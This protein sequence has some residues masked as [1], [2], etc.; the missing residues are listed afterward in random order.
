MR[1][2]NFCVKNSGGAVA[3]DDENEYYNMLL[4]KTPVMLLIDVAIN[5]SHHVMIAHKTARE[6]WVIQ[7]FAE[8]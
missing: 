5:R 7:P 1:A 4:K 3:F 8:K 6:M 2:N